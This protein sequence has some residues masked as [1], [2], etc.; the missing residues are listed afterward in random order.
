MKSVGEVMAIGRKFEEAF[1]K[2]LRMV[3]ENVNGF[4][5]YVKPVNDEELEKPTDKRMFVLAASIK[6]GYTVDRLYE[7]T[8]I[9]RWFLEKMKN[10][11]DYYTIL[12]NTDHTKL[13]HDVL[14]GAK[15]IGFSDKQI[16]A[17]VKSSELAVRLQRQEHRIL[18]MVKQIDTVAAEW[19]ATTNYL[20]LTYSGTTDDVEFPGGY[21]MV[22]GKCYSLCHCVD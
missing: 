1:Q 8:K 21:T 3:D 14:L 19:P 6:A 16:A 9:D 22:I 2:A 12:E 15:K 5:P 7:L 18:P 11:I 20:Y 4:D 17:V 13:M 10:I